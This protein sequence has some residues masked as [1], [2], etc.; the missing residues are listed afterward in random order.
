MMDVA[1]LPPQMLTA[2]AVVAT[3]YPEPGAAHPAVLRF[4][5]VYATYRVLLRNI[6]VQKFGIPPRDADDLVHD[7]FATYLSN[8]ANVRELHPY[9][10]GAICNASRAY[11]RR[12]H[13]APFCDAMTENACAATP[14]DELLNTVIGNLTIDATLSRMGPSCR[15]TLRRFYLLGETAV[16]IARTRDTSPNYISRLLNY[17]RNRAK[18]IYRQIQRTA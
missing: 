10:I 3:A 11:R 7:V 14:D 16:S 12:Q 17:C 1:N 2:A 9:L 6:A 15:D 4:E 5:A 13:A 8:P 18:T